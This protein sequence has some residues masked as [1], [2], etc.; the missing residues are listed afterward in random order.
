MRSRAQL[1]WNFVIVRQIRLWN[2]MTVRLDSTE[3]VV[4]RCT[5]HIRDGRLVDP[6]INQPLAASQQASRD[7]CGQ[8]QSIVW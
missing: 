2:M 6:A 1:V 5:E 4:I 8:L 3:K 7:V